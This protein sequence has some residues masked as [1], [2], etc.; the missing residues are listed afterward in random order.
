LLAIDEG[1]VRGIRLVPHTGSGAS[2]LVRLGRLGDEAVALARALVVLGAGVEVA[3]AAALVGLD[4]AVGELIADRLAAAEILAPVRP[5]QFADRSIGEAIGRDIAPGALRV[6]HRRAAEL[7]DREGSGSLAR[8]AAHL[9]AS[10]PARDR[11]VVGRLHAAALEALERGSPK[12]AASYLH[13]ALSEPPAAD[14]R[15][16]LLFLLGSAEWCAGEPDAIPHLEQALAAARDDPRSQIAACSV[17]A[18]AYVVWDRADCAVEV[19]E[20]ALAAVGPRDTSLA[21]SERLGTIEPEPLRDTRLALTIE[22]R[23]ATVGLLNERTA[24]AASHRAEHLRDW[25]KST[26]DPPVDLLVTLAEYAARTNR[27]PEAQELADRA[28]ACEAF[29]FPLESCASLIATLTILERYDGVQRLCE[30]ALATLRRPAAVH[31]T[32]SI[33]VLRA[34]ASCDRGALLD[35]KADAL[36]A[37]E[38]TSGVH[39]IHAASGLIRV[40]IE[41]DE[42]DEAEHQLEQLA[43][44]CQSSSLE[45]AHFLMARGR[46]RHAQGRLQNA[47]ADFQECGQ[48]SQRLGVWAPGAIPWRA[49]AALAH[50]ALGDTG[51]AWR[52]AAEQLDLAREFDR[53]RTLGV[54]LRAC[55]LIQGGETGLELLREA[56]HTLERSQSPLELARALSNYGAALRRAG[57]RVQARTELKRAL[58]LAHHLG[59]RRVASQARDELIAAGAKPRRDAITGRDALTASELRVARL[60]AQGLT[61]REIAQ[62]LFITTKTAKSHLNRVYRKLEIN[63]R[64]QL[65]DAMSGVIDDG[66]WGGLEHQCDGDFFEPIRPKH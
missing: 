39:R 63:R 10:G 33:L 12:L 21:V 60:A 42:L 16:A 18:P 34:T 13:R 31:D 62:A 8:V 61:N 44:P 15:A 59:A 14:E 9:L 58:D 5:L 32:T 7:A 28:L 4:P 20:R 36:W 53:P 30:N 1:S 41:H 48:R 49:E 6:A 51:E 50:A 26:P 23:A 27:A 11:W 45:A 35:A 38:R 17:L 66:A 22:A 65:A 64:G 52:L 37:L 19:L 2:V 25:L 55:G 24:A 3:L 57:R 47:L 29:P 40:L 46:L 54:S 56:V 43:D